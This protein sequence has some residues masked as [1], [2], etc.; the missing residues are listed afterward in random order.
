MI[1]KPDHYA[2]LAHAAVRNAQGV[3]KEIQARDFLTAQGH[4]VLLLGQVNELLRW[5]TGVVDLET[6][7]ESDPLRNPY[8]SVFIAGPTTE[9]GLRRLPPEQLLEHCRATN[10][11]MNH[12]RDEQ[13]RWWLSKALSRAEHEL[14]RRGL[15]P[16]SWR[17]GTDAE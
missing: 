5:L 14:R 11:S 16:S 12:A 17:D 4:A 1:Q 3:R 7:G 15:D 2:S 6:L 10:W 9:G 8:D 13:A